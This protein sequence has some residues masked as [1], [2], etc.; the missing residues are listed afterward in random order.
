MNR[1][2]EIRKA[3]PAAQRQAV[4]TLVAS[5]CAGAL[6]FVAFDRYRV[7]LGDWVLADPGPRVRFVF[8]LMA[9]L[10]LAPLVALTVWLWS[11]GRRAIRAREFPPPGLRIIRDTVILTGERAVSRGNLLKALALGCA[12]GCALLGV[13]LSRVAVLLSQ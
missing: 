4:C 2:A 3:D 1:E 8:L 10:V 5:A 9:V 7:P 6:L 13:L 12:A 11:V